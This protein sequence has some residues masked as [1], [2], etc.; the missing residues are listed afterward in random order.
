MERDRKKIQFVFD[1]IYKEMGISEHQIRSKVRK[2]EILDARRLFFYVMRNYFKYSFEKAGKITLHNHATVLHA[3]R[4]F[5]D[6]TVPY[7]KITT[8]PYKDIC[9]QLDLMK[10]SVEQQLEELQEKTIIINKKINELLTI[11][12]LQNGRRKKLHS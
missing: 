1:Y 4:T 11:K 12:Q 3:C 9:F 2:R 7:P 5:N 6:Y 8:L 10:D